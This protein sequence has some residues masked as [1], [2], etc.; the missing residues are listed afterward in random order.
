[1]IT[2][3]IFLPMAEDDKSL[4]IRFP[5]FGKRVQKLAAAKLVSIREIQRTVGVGYE[6]ARRY[7]LGVSKPDDAGM[8][9]MATLLGVSPS[10]LDWGTKAERTYEDIDSDHHQIRFYKDVQLSAGHGVN[11]NGHKPPKLMPVPKWMLPNDVTASSIVIVAVKG[12]SMTGELEDGALVCVDTS[13]KTKFKN[14]KIYAYNDGEETSVKYFY[15]RV[16]GGILIKAKNEIEFPE[17]V[18]GPYDVH[19]LDVIGR[20][21]AALNRYWL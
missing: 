2:L 6:M 4:I 20:V 5:E 15:T 1:M 10:E 19:K 8:Q 18:I 16:G 11:N 14:G 13:D 3:D 17:Q 7:W 21:I 12:Q 9:L